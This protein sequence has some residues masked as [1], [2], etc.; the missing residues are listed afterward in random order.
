MEE[1][2]YRWDGPPSIE[3]LRH[4]VTLPTGHSYLSHTLVTADGRRGVVIVAQREGE[5]L[6]VR[7][8]RPAVG[9]DMWELPRGFGISD[10][11]D[12]AG[13]VADGLR[14][15]REETG[16]DARDAVDLGGYVTD[17]SI[18]PTEVRVIGC[19]IDADAQPVETDGETSERRWVPRAGLAALI[20]D[21]VLADAHSLAALA[22]VGTGGAGSRPR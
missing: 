10:R 3:L 16:Y 18:M 22:I 2:V 11:D 15:L 20:A 21:G 6:I 5:V 9:R 13:S 1:R 4:P 14:E 19:E 12:P 8:H 17:S 7:S